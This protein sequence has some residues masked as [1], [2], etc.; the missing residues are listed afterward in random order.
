MKQSYTELGYI[1]LEFE[2]DI[3]MEERRLIAEDV[4]RL[5][6]GNVQ[7]VEFFKD[8][9]KAAAR[10]ETPDEQRVNELVGNIGR[11]KGIKKDSIYVRHLT[12]YKPY[13]EFK[14]LERLTKCI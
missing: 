12:V 6:N 4:V 8:R 14:E 2:P 7:A 11:I 3:S 1:I 9:Y 10:F 5:G 13:I